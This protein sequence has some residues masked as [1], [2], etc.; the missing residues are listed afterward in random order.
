MGEGGGGQGPALSGQ[1]GEKT[2]IYL[3]RGLFV[4]YIF[5][6]IY[7]AKQYSDSQST[8]FLATKAADR[9]SVDWLSEYFCIIASKTIVH[10]NHQT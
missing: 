10:N 7:I 5:V 3:Y 8:E 9:N 4:V 2:P 6:Y 1:A